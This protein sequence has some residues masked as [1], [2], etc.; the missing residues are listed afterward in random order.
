MQ[1]VHPLDGSKIKGLR[2]CEKEMLSK[3][4]GRC[5][6]RIQMD[7]F[8][9]SLSGLSKMFCVGARRAPLNNRMNE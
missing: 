2:G 7:C 5:P 1:N 4:S 8:I 3:E 6:V 9:G